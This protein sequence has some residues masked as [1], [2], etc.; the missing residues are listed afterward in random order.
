LPARYDRAREFR[1][2]R[3]DQDVGV[4]QDVPPRFGLLQG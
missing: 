4:I 1:V 3:Y 2:V